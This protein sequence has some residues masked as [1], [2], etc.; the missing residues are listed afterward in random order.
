MGVQKDKIELKVAANVKVDIAKNS[1]A[2][3][4]TPRQ[5]EK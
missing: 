5:K 3:I 4:L 2:V 1:I